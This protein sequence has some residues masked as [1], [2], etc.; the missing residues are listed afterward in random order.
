MTRGEVWWI[1]FDPP[2]G[3][4]PAVLMSRR[5]AYSVRSA[6]TVVP[7]TR[8]IRNIPTEVLLDQADGVPRRSVANADAIITVAKSRIQTN[9]CTLSAAKLDAVE[10]SIKF[11]LD[12]A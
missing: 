10:Q 11:A 3:R 2:I 6:I 7:L 4:R 8:T 1:E 12:L 9:I 5:R